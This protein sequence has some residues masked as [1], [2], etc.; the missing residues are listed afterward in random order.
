MYDLGP[1]HVS[2]TP[3]EETHLKMP[4]IFSIPLDVLDQIIGY[5]DH[6]SVQ[7]LSFTCK[8]AFHAWDVKKHIY[9]QLFAKSDPSIM[10]DIGLKY[11]YC[12]F[13]R[14]LDSLDDQ[15]GPLVQQIA[16]P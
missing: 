15:T 14:F 12:R 4:T 10:T 7:S 13:R 2:T 16:I 9:R 11:Q 8:D 1:P 5:L 3:T 6:R